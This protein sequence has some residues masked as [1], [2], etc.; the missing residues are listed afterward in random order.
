MDSNTEIIALYLPQFY[1]FKENSR[2]WGA[3]FTEWTNVAKA[4]PLFKGHEQ[5]RIP[6][7][8]SFYDL[9]L[10]EVREEQVRLAK[11]AGVT[12]FCY[13]HYWF[14]GGRQLLTRV[15]DEVLASGKPDFKFCLGWANH[16]WY[17]KTWDKSGEDRL[18]IEQRYTGLD[19]AK[20]HF[21][22][23]L[24]AFK[25]KR[26]LKIDG[27]PFLFI[28]DPKQLPTAYIYHFEL[29]AKQA[30]FDGIYLVANLRPFD[31]KRHYLSIGY[32]A[33]LINRITR[34]TKTDIALDRH[35][36]KV[37][38]LKEIFPSIG[39]LR[40]LLKGFRRKPEIVDYAT[41]YPQLTT[42]EE[43]SEQVIPQLVP[44]WDHTPRSGVHGTAWINATPE[45]F[46]HHAKQVLEAVSK[47][48][49]K[50]IILKSWNE[51]GEGNYMEP[52]SRFGHG[53]INALRR[54]IDESNED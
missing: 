15:F 34:Y 19:D 32:S 42:E 45:N 51:W 36:A 10:A 9:R 1:P 50:L 2:W 53:F 25:D 48:R 33:V 6:A 41:L 5:P 24:R 47:K 37:A 16:S 31:D 27:K 49:N 13:W 39:R 38:R 40:T 35:R 30:G 14:G 4:K 18:L 21:D 20:S 17:A 23:L 22:Y 46:Y 26:Y 12:A 52:D 54:A 43:L 29:W 44:Q 11:K 7:D 3:G 8:L 28:F